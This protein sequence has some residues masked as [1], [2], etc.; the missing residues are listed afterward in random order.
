MHHC[1][2]TVE[3]IKSSNLDQLLHKIIKQ[4]YD[5]SFLEKEV[6]TS[7]FNS[8]QL[9]VKKSTAHSLNSPHEH[10]MLKLK[11]KYAHIIHDHIEHNQRVV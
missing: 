9:V 6:A 4:L 2:I 1:R 8:L 3:A 7:Y 11:K 10:G 5:G